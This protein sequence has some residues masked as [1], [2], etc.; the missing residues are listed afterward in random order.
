[1]KFLRGHEKM[2]P[3]FPSRKTF[4]KKIQEKK[5]KHFCE[6]NIQ[7]DFFFP[8]VIRVKKIIIII[9]VKLRK[10]KLKNSPR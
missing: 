9:Y 6:K 4:E 10:E 8:F 5:K 1:M 3:L 2:F 7:E